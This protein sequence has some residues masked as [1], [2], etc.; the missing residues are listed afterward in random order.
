[1]WASISSWGTAQLP[2]HLDMQRQQPLFCAMLSSWAEV[3]KKLPKHIFPTEQSHGYW[4]RPCHS[5]GSG[6]THVP[7]AEGPIRNGFH[8]SED[9]PWTK[10]GLRELRQHN[11][12]W[13][14]NKCSPVSLIFQYHCPGSDLRLLKQKGKHAAIL[15][16]TSAL[17]RLSPLPPPAPPPSLPEGTKFCFSGLSLTAQSSSQESLQLLPFLFIAFRISSP[18]ISLS[19]SP[20][21]LPAGLWKRWDKNVFRLFIFI[22]I[23]GA[24][25]CFASLALENIKIWKTAECIVSSHGCSTASVHKLCS[26]RAAE[27]HGSTPTQQQIPTQVRIL[28]AQLLHFPLIPSEPTEWAAQPTDR[29]GTAA[30][31]CLKRFQGSPH[32]IALCQGSTGGSSPTSQVHCVLRWPEA[33]AEMLQHSSDAPVQ[34][35]GLTRFISS[36]VLL[37]STNQGFL[38]LQPQLSLCYV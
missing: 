37:Q 17:K 4:N 5:G 21:R 33:K 6:R 22:W 26:P 20:A 10:R 13:A 7:R 8:H 30:A 14:L 28:T 24:D 18:C 9:I 12:R 31:P 19:P 11:R 36:L 15:T 32:S 1:M 34:K 38:I 16:R 27:L 2:S 3:C 29:P 23:L 35:R 25:S